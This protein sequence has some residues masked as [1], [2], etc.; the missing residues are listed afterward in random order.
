MN[1]KQSRQ[2]NYRAGSSDGAKGK[3]SNSPGMGF[4]KLVGAGV[5]FLLGGPGGA[6]IGAAIGDSKSECRDRK[7]YKKG[8]NKHKR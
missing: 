4:S 3:N 7:S 8:Y 1:S 5:G 6:F 2:K